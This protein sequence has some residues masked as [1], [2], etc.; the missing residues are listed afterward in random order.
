MISRRQAI[1]LCA[2]VALQSAVPASASSSRT[3]RRL[4]YQVYGNPSGP[5]VFYFHGVPGSRLEAA[6]IRCEAQAA[7]VR[8][9][10]VDRPGMGLSSYQC[11]RRILD[12]PREVASLADRLGLAGERFGVVGMSGGAPY[13]AACALR[14]PQRLTHVAIVSGHAPM[15]APG[16][17]P[18]DDDKM[19]ELVARRPHLA[20]KVFGL[21]DRRLDRRP[22]KVLRWATN[23]W[24]EDDTRL[25]LCDPTHR[26]MLLANLRAATACGVEGIITDIQLLA[27]CWGFRLRDIHGVGVSIWQGGC[28]PVV[29]PSM[30]RYFQ[31]QIAG[32]E[33]TVL[34]GAGHVSNLKTQAV[35]ILTRAAAG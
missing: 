15:G 32:S 8:L 5:P 17:C 33:L 28:D 12:W 22:D 35:E 6:L 13:A 1:A 25:V 18:G 30:G 9:I 29:T 31:S 14:I 34:P 4:G 19:I 21:A 11:G 27:G 3:G 2:G 10:A 16:V 23:S 26:R 20:E 24:T 7:G